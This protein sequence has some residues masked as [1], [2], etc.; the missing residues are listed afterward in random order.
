VAG[1]HQ[2][3]GRGQGRRPGDRARSHRSRG[4]GDRSESFAVAPPAP[5]PARRPARPA[6]ARPWPAGDHH[7]RLGAERGRRPHARPHPRAAVFG[8]AAGAA[9]RSGPHRPDPR[10]GRSAR[11]CAD[12]RQH[13]PAGPRPR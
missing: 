4:A 8:G 2:R 9:P 10:R 3:C 5:R 1:P 13:L 11:R 6:L 7:G 12:G